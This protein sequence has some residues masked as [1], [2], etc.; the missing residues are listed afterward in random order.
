MNVA[1]GSKG[2]LLNHQDHVAAAAWSA[3][4]KRLATVSSIQTSSGPIPA[5]LI[6]DPISGAQI[7][8]L[9]QPGAVRSLAFSPDGKQIATIDGSQNLQVWN[10]D[11]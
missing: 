9:P 3:D 1:D 10:L 11:R 2:P 6:W 4:G 5:V 7:S 8:V